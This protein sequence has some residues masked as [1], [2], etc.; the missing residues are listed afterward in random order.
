M[1]SFADFCK[2]LK[3]PSQWAHATSYQHLL[4]SMSVFPDAAQEPAARVLWCRYLV[5][6][7]RLNPHGYVYA[8]RRQDATQS[9]KIG[10][11]KNPVQRKAQLENGTPYELDLCMLID[12]EVSL[13]TEFHYT[14][15]D[16]RVRGEWY[17]STQWGSDYLPMLEKVAV[18]M[19][20]YDSGTTDPVER[21]LVDRLRRWQEFVAKG[22]L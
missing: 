13:E 2:V 15:R 22:V 17:D 6:V 18:G 20:V 14:L 3:I 1:K 19:P 12:G 16:S 21:E 4:W 11:S 5:E 8:F 7:N 10:F 9:V